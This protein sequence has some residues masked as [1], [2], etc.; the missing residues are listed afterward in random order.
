MTPEQKTYWLR[1]EGEELTKM[2]DFLM[3]NIG[4]SAAKAATFCTTNRETQDAMARQI[5]AIM[6]EKDGMW[7]DVYDRQ[8]AMEPIP[9]AL[10]KT[11][12]A[13]W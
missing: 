3:N 5:L 9:M 1:L 8:S 11:Y 4:L 13:C 2:F 10:Y 7:E 6:F 12:R